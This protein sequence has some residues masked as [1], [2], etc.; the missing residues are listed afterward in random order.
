MLQRIWKT[1][2]VLVC[3]CEEDSDFPFCIQILKNACGE[4]F[5]IKV[6]CVN[7]NVQ[8]R[9]DVYACFGVLMCICVYVSRCIWKS[10]D[11][12]IWHLNWFYK[13][14]SSVFKDSFLLSKLFFFIQ[15]FKN[16]IWKKKNAK[17]KIFYYI[18]MILFY[19]INFSFLPLSIYYVK[20]AR[21]GW[22]IYILWL[23]T[24]KLCSSCPYY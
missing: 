5:C 12:H 4:L 24:W 6:T 8:K 22:N 19:I 3:D 10:G 9:L 21:K 13:D 18:Y 7:T 20:A 2:S 11:T 1:W 23:I 17:E 15:K 16:L 14:I